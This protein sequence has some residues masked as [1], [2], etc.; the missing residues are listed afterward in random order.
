M[1][2]SE[3]VKVQFACNIANIR[4]DDEVAVRTI[5]KV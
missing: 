1:S 4:C 5:R 3:K 2:L